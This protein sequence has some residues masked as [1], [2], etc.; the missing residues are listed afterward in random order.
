M[1][2]MKESSK[3]EKQTQGHKT[4]RLMH[5]FLWDLARENKQHQI[6]YLISGE[7]HTTW[8]STIADRSLHIKG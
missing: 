4:A 7:V 5:I 3:A 6:N 2:K 8:I 1:L